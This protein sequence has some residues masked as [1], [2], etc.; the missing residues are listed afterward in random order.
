MDL[1]RKFVFD[2][3]N[4]SGDLKNPPPQKPRQ[5]GPENAGPSNVPQKQTGVGVAAALISTSTLSMT[6]MTFMA[7]GIAAYLVLYHT[8]LIKPQ[9]GSRF[10]YMGKF[11]CA[12]A[13]TIAYAAAS[14]C[15]PNA[16][17]K[18]NR[19]FF[20]QVA[21][22]QQLTRPSRAAFRRGLYEIPLPKPEPRP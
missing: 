19:D 13:W 8:N 11:G 1:S 15:A 22:P 18:T 12:G 21:I 3:G 7:A 20:H 4:G 14:L 6:A 16:L 2:G 17:A 9:P 5:G 10:D